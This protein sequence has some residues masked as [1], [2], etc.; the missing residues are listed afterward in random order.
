MYLLPTHTLISHITVLG[1]DPKVRLQQTFP[2]TRIVNNYKTLVVNKDGDC[3]MACVVDNKPS[4]KKV[5]I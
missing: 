3:Y 4:D 5:C 1:A 2:E